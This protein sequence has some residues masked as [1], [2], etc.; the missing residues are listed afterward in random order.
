MDLLENL[1]EGMK[2]IVSPDNL[3][4]IG[5]TILQL[6]GIIILAN[7]IKKL[8]YMLID[9]LF[10]KDQGEELNRANQR[11][12]TLNTLLKSAIRYLIYFIGVTMSLEVLGIPT[13]SILAGAGVVGLAVG[14]GARSL[15]EDVITGFFILFEDQF[16]VGDYIE[17]AGV[18]GIVEG[19][20]LRIT[21]IKNFDGDLHIVP[22]GNIKQV[23]NY[24]VADTRVLVDVGI[25]YEE[26]VSEVINI[27]K[28]YCLEL[29]QDMKGINEGPQVLGVENLGDSSVVLRILAWTPPLKKWDVGRELKQKIKE[30]LDREGIEIPY[31]KQVIINGDEEGDD[32]NEV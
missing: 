26:D 5:T 13:S 4:L 31:P 29:A 27:L 22:N 32:H 12:K 24:T 17:T 19:I 16:S 23:T 14:F 20:D 11:V 8:A 6:A 2:K 18:S 30:K 15:V 1:I 28:D 7:I 3:I 9:S 10:N 21:K 25:S